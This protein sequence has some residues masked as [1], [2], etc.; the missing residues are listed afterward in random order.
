MTIDPV[1]GIPVIRFCDKLDGYAAGV[2]AGVAMAKELRMKE[3][4]E[5]QQAKPAQAPPPVPDNPEL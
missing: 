1:L 2:A 5:T 3:A 4:M